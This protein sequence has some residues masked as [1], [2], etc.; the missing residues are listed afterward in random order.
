MTLHRDGECETCNRIMAEVDLAR[1][2]LLP[3]D[4]DAAGADRAAETET[5]ETP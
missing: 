2:A 1:A 5:K 3:G 4:L